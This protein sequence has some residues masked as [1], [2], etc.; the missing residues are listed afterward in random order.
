MNTKYGIPFGRKFEK[1]FHD[2][3][4]KHCKGRATPE[5][6]AAFEEMSAIRNAPTEWEK[7][8]MARMDE[9]VQKLKSFF[10]ITDVIIGKKHQQ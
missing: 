4:V 6:E 3:L 9:E 8:E 5:E 2:L 10:D 1:K 7:Q